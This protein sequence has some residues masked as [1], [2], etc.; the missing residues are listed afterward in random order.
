MSKEQLPPSGHGV[1]SVQHGKPVQVENVPQT[2]GP[3]DVVVVTVLV[4]VLVVAQ[5]P[6]P[7]AS[8]QLA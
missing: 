8:Q 3:G 5:L 6:A 4:V 7:Q 1:T 2:I